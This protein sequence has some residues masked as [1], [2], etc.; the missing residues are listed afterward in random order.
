MAQWKG[1]WGLEPFVQQQVRLAILPRD[2]NYL[3]ST[4]NSW[5]ERCSRQ[6]AATSY[7]RTF[8]E[9]VFDFQSSWET[10]ERTTHLPFDE[11]TCS[12]QGGI[13]HGRCVFCGTTNPEA[14]H[15]ESK[16]NYGECRGKVRKF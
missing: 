6:H 1:E 5:P 15:L 4:A 14:A 8:C 11:W 3:C 7:P 2:R 16:H 9:E 13:D 12:P 10:H